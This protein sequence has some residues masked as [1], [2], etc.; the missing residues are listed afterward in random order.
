MTNLSKPKGL[1]TKRC[2]KCGKEKPIEGFYKAS[3][4]EDGH[5][6]DCKECGRARDTIYR[7][8]NREK[9]RAWR[10]KGQEIYRRKHQAELKLWFQ[11]HRRANKAK[12]RAYE[13]AARIQRAVILHP[14]YVK[15]LLCKR[16]ILGFSDIPNELVEVKTLSLK[17]NKL[18]RRA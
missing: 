11:R 5:R 6:S 15:D 1:K 7:Q 16:T 12:I 10:R 17:I 2:T 8:N 9:I 14:S 18:L 13:R 3:R 4:H